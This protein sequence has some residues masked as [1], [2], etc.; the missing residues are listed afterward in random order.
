MKTLV[1]F[2]HTPSIEDLGQNIIGQCMCLCDMHVCMHA[3]HFKLAMTFEILDQDFVT[4]CTCAKASLNTL[5]VLKFF[6]L[7]L[8]LSDDF[9][10][11]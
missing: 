8:L 11:N 1:N 7:L 6:M 5:H 10:P 3:T 2:F 9:F 4:Y